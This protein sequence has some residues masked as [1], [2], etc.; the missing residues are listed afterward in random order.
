MNG[1]FKKTVAHH[2][3]VDDDGVAGQG[4]FL[5]DSVDDEGNPVD[6]PLNDPDAAAD[7]RTF[8][9]ALVST[10]EVLVSTDKAEA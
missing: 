8:D 5:F 3:P 1:H 9:A 4:D 6:D 7:C 2:F 10:D